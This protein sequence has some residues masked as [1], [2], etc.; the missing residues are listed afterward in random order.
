MVR[1]AGFHCMAP[2]L[3]GS[4]MSNVLPWT[5]RIDVADRVAALIRER[6]PAGHAH[7]VGLSLGGAIAH[8]LLARHPGF[9]DRVVIDGAGVLP[10]WRNTPFLIG[11]TGIAPFLHTRAVIAGL[12][13]SVG[14]MPAPVRADLRVASRRAFLESYRDALAT[15]VTTA[16]VAAA[17]PTLLVGGER[18]TAVRQSNAALA[19]VMP[20]AIARY[21]PGLGHGWLGTRLSLPVEMVQAWLMQGALPMGLS[22]EVQWPGAIARLRRMLETTP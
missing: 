16:E 13:R 18:E 9:L 2:D 21:V 20:A 8:T 5:S 10:S 3:P 1:L 19:A 11:L 17:C 14:G 15:E 22:A 4:G 12:S 6:V 7:L